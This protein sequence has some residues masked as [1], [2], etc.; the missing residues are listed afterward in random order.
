LASQTHDGQPTHEKISISKADPFEHEVTLPPDVLKALLN[1]DGIK[2]MLRY[3]TDYQRNHP[4]ELFFAT[5][6]HLGRTD[7]VDFIVGGMPPLCGASF[8][9][10]W[11]V[12]P[13]PKKPKLLLS[14]SGNVIELMD[15]RTKGYRD[16]RTVGGT[17]WIFDEEVYHF[18]GKK[19]KLWKRKVENRP[20]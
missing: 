14:A 2:S 10:Y 9:W 6:A 1:D 19:Y 5:E 20:H 8:D 3:A 4:S 15:S 17:F 13:I 11:V 16:I 12:L 18:D 7:E